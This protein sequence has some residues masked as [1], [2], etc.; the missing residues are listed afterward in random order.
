MY[1]K[2]E[3]SKILEVGCYVGTSIVEMLKIVKDSTATVID[4]WV[5]YHEH[6][7]IENLDTPVNFMNEDTEKI[8][9]KNTIG[10][11]IKVLKGKSSDK[12]IELIKLNETFNF[13][14]IDA[15]HKVMDVFLDATLAWKL[16]KI[17]G[18]LA[19]DDYC[20][21][22]GDVLNSPFEAIEYFKEQQKDNFVILHVGYRVFLKKIN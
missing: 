10:L 21:N 20:F 9:Y 15:S 3:K 4:Q 2:L 16:L 14:Y 8:F 12:L 11:P 5:S 6:D 13:I 17:G 19:F 1:M 22:K 18:I 7:N